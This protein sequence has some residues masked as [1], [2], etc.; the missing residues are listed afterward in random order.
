MDYSQIKHIIGA[1]LDESKMS[2]WEIAYEV[3]VG[4]CAIVS[5]IMVCLD[6]FTV[7]SFKHSPYVE[8]DSAILVILWADYIS[9][10]EKADDKKEFFMCHL[11]G[12]ISIIP[13]AWLTTVMPAVST[14]S[15]ASLLKIT[16]ITMLLRV[17]RAFGYFTI[18]HNRIERILKYLP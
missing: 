2:K 9:A 7:L 6:Y 17:F 4:M 14:W 12:L 11:I 13:I 16:K 10:F 15:G 5:V 18:L 1:D 8:I 3:F